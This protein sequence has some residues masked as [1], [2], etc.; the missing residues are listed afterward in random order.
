MV[1]DPEEGPETIL[2]LLEVGEGPVQELGEVTVR[3]A[4]PV[5]QAGFLIALGAEELDARG[6]FRALI[7][8]PLSFPDD[9]ARVAPGIR[10]EGIRILLAESVVE[11]ESLPP[12]EVVAH[13]GT[14]SA[15]PSR[16]SDL[17]WAK[18]GIPVTHD[19]PSI[20]RMA[21]LTPART[22]S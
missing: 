13:V 11:P 19:D 17:A 21:R 20:L 15:R 10:K 16:Q 12:V 3:A 14:R 18:N 4:R 8:L 2:L 5:E 1:V 22:D 7:P 9:L 6:R